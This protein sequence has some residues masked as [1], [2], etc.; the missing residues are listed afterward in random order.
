MS[1]QHPFVIGGEAV[2]TWKPDRGP[3]GVTVRA[4]VRRRLTAAERRGLAE[5]ADRYSRFLGTP[6]RVTIT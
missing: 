6:V 1:F 2:G 5:A 4:A 3:A